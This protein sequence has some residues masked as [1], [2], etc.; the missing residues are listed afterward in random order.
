VNVTN[1][2]LIV[3][4]TLRRDH[5]APYG[6][7]VRTPVLDKF[8]KVSTVFDRHYVHN[9][10]TVPARTDMY[11]GRYTSAYLDWQPLSRNEVVLSE[12]LS[13]AG[14]TTFLIG[15]TY[16]MFRD[17]Y[18]F[19]R[20]FTGFEWIRGNGG[21]RWQTHPRNPELPAQPERFYDVENY[22]KRYLRNAQQ[23]TGER[24]YPVARTMLGA[25]TWLEQNYR[26]GPFFLHVDTFDPHEPWDPPRWYVDLYDADYRG[27]E[28][29]MPRYTSVDG[30]LTPAELRHCRALYA[31]S[32]TMVDVWLGE[33][34]RKVETLGLL[35]DTAIIF[36]TDHGFFLGERGWIG[37][38]RIDPIAQ[39]QHWLPLYEELAHIPLIVY[40]PGA[41]PGRS[42]ALTQPVD[43]APTVYEFLG[44]SRPSTVQGESLIPLLTGA[45]SA[46]RSF[47]WSGLALHHRG[48]WRPSTITTEE[49]SFIYNG[50]LGEA[51]PMWRIDAVDGLSRQETIPV[52][53]SIP[54]L[55]LGPQLYHLPSDPLQTKNLYR[56]K[57]GVAQALHTEHIG[58]LERLGVPANSVELM[59]IIYGAD[60]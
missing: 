54:N 4:D 15:D 17:D 37:K 32:V 23:R 57:P 1:V 39:Q 55:D 49:W 47:A 6:S 33:L 10:P 59:K 13:Q 50:A 21:D 14:L 56:E 31:A 46:V 9:F 48:R 3:S 16:N 27:E 24:D 34:L 35:E 40:A 22:L 41:R 51:D 20:G 58:L 8:A 26:E 38:T 19:S 5:L 18:F 36:T 28:V 25:A 12:V 44:V 11:T 45:K 30:Y 29:I 53:G 60:R 7:R 42:G 43:L 2:I 52:E